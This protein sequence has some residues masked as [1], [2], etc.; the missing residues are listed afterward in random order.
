MER[1]KKIFH[2]DIEPQ[3]LKFL[4][5]SLYT[6]VYYVLAELIANA[7]DADADKVYI[8][9]EGTCL[10]V[11]DNGTG[12]SYEEGDVSNYLKV[13]NETRINESQSKTKGGRLKMG[14]KGVGKLAALAAS[15]E[16][17]V[18]TVKNN[19]KT[20]FIL[21][22]D[23]DNSGNLEE[24]PESETHLKII[25][26]NGTSIQMLNPEYRLNKGLDVIARNI[27]KL[28]P[29]I[30]NDFQIII[31]N[32]NGRT[33]TIS[34]NDMSIIS[35][36][37]ALI[38]LGDEYGFLIDGIDKKLKTSPYFK[39]KDAIS[40]EIYLYD[41]DGVQQKY[42]LIIKGW[43]GAYK[44][45]KD[46]KVED[47][48]FSENYLSIYSRGKIG[49]FNIL[50]RIGS[51]RLPEVYVVGQLH[52]DLLED[53]SLP[54]MALSNRQGYRDDDPR[55]N[56]VLEK[57][58]QLLK[59]IVNLR[60]KWGEEQS[61]EKRKKHFQDLKNKEDEFR[62]RVFEYESSVVDLISNQINKDNADKKTI[63]HIVSSVLKEKASLLDLK[64]QIDQNKKKILISHT[65]E[66]KDFADLIYKALLFNNFQKE[67][68]IYTSSE[69]QESRIPEDYPIYDYLRDFFV[70]SISNKKVFVI[71]AT[72]KKMSSSWGAVLEVG[73]SWITK[74]DHKIFNLRTDNDDDYKPE[75]PLNVNVEWQQSWRTPEGSILIDQ[76]NA[77]K[78]C[79]K[80][81]AICDLFKIP[82]KNR[83]DNIDFLKRNAIVQ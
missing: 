53:S 62:A 11:E 10:T 18:I 56:M 38:T 55:Y 70:N 37:A 20:G 54:D 22:R 61:K 68:I 3:I 42:N 66:D 69:N 28:F 26:G 78:F 49:E 1:T 17:H 82:H 29:V 44:S 77:D 47:K 79:A 39:K 9:D 13:A 32:A 45:T 52:V 81:E 73:A 46:R 80:I 14:R 48:E 43:I 59:D 21:K 51:N 72:S 19:E 23:I 75:I 2:I 41:R 71:Y 64:P 65:G 24:L 5:P 74:L 67:D 40:D 76:I 83:N 33:K 4:G 16:V 50:P 6:N 31:K 8:I 58:S 30:S 25:E 35:E 27:L 63:S 12:M 57:A 34:G 36:F 15:K 7:W 60:V